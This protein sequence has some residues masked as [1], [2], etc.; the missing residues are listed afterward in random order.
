M[1]FQMTAFAAGPP[2]ARVRDMIARYF[3]H[4]RRIREGK[5]PEPLEPGREWKDGAFSIRRVNDTREADANT[6]WPFPYDVA[7]TVV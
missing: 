6:T 4:R 7:L 5:A 2:E 1:R 3:E